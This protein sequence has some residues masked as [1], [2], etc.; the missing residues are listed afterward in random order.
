MSDVA[1]V[2]AVTRE[3]PDNIPFI[4]TEALICDAINIWQA[5][6]MELFEH[7]EETLSVRFA[8]FVHVECNQYP[9]L[10]FLISYVSGTHPYSTF[11]HRFPGPS[12]QTT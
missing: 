2:R 10:E 1:F 7:V 9:Q 8:E 5:P 12:S 11:A 3:L 6:A 4:V